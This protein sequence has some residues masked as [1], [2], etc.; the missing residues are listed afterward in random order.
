MPIKRILVPT[1]F[2]ASSEYACQYALT[3]AHEARAEVYLLHAIYNPLRL[4]G[5]DFGGVIETLV[6][7]AQDDLQKQVEQIREKQVIVHPMVL[8]GVEYEEIVKFAQEHQ[9][10]LII[11]GTHG[12]T[13]LAH[14]F[15]GSVAER[16]I[17]IAS[18]PVLIVRMPAHK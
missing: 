13:G 15:L 4:P 7:Q 14:A 16:V 6:K 11:M 17:R 2:S 18:C 12:R 8:V 10:D 3:F 9:I 1:D 5:Y